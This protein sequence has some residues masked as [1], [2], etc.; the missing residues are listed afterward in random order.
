MFS[1]KY[2]FPFHPA[3]KVGKMTL[4]SGYASPSKGVLG[5]AVSNYTLGGLADSYYL[6]ARPQVTIFCIIHEKALTMVD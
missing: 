4:Y 2:F 3:F 1:L 6:A 5:A